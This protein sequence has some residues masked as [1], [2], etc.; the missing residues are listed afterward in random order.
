MERR[1]SL[2]Q[3]ST[4]KEQGGKDNPTTETRE[5]QTNGRRFEQVA[6]D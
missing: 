5:E 6:T 4:R 1:R 2:S 3:R